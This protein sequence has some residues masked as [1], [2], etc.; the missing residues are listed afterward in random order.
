MASSVAETLIGAVV[1]GAAGVF[2]VYAANTA[3]VTVVRGGYDLVA[4]FQ[5]AEG[6][7]AGG[8][9]RIA[10]VKVGSIRA[11]ELD[12]ATYQAVVTLTIR[13]G[14]AIPDDTSA[15]ITAAGLLGDNF[16]ALA[17]GGSDIMLE[18]G[19]EIAFTQS[20]FSITEMAG[21]LIHGGDAPVSE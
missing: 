12:P 8:D 13:E 14:I 21:K 7:A 5:R 19:E 4:K 6:L 18:P 3:D 17:P 1:L 10:G 9:V 11:M 2:L 20:S 16:V 15:K